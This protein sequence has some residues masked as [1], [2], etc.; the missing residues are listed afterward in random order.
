MKISTKIAAMI[1]ISLAI[2]FA[3]LVFE[4][5]LIS[6]K[7]IAY[8]KQELIVSLKE[9]KK[10]ALQEEVDIISSFIE[11]V[12][13]QYQATNISNEETTTDIL[14][15]TE[16]IKFGLGGYVIIIDDKG[17]IIYHPN[18]EMFKQN[19]TDINGFK[20]V[21]KLIETSVKDEYVE[22]ALLDTNTKSPVR[23]IAN[24]KKINVGGKDMIFI[25]TA[26]MEDAY[27]RA[28]EL[29]KNMEKAA[30]D[31]TKT[32]I[33]MAL[34]IAV[35][36]LILT[37]LYSRASITKP[38]NTLIDRARNLSSGDGDLTRKLEINGKDEIAQ[39]SE[40][41][42]NFI[43]K[44]RILISDAKHLS[45]E[46]SSIANELS[47][48]SL[49]TGKRVE[50]S[51]LIVNNTTQKGEEIQSFMKNS[52][53]FAEESKTELQNASTHI[54]SANKA[55]KELADQITNSAQVESEM[56]VK[57]EQLSRDAEQVK[58]VLDVINDI[59]DQTNLLALNAAIEAARAGEHGRG[60]AVVADEVRK[61][62]ERTQSSLVE[63][64]ATISVIVQAI[65]DSSER[66]SANS[67]TIQELT[68]VAN[69]VENTINVMS[70]AMN[71]AI[72]MS[73]KTTE[74]FI[75][76]GKGVNLMMEGISNI[77]HI[78]TENARSVEEIAA[79][80]EHLNKM[81][82]TLNNKLAEFRT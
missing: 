23:K 59:A 61:L 4:N 69:R 75:N 6:D 52:V 60:F 81:T 15:Y 3:A 64:N 18:A 80:A 19:L 65:G 43:E 82:D 70:E 58:S 42:N 41:I 35:A 44:V 13:R 33:M 50:D 47:S 28:D 56:A 63:I 31:G 22:Y 78:A 38:L 74:D 2:L 76:T 10:V 40:A 9:D 24:S 45:S 37:M 25:I 79:A 30:N 34:G 46:N 62:A 17:Q 57:I 72:G 21:D 36:V 7:S 67:K 49:Q 68:N 53:S 77:N 29:G 8:T 66:M 39:A 26:S 20:Y 48:T 11:T 5:K 16:A 51:T 73:D 27:A 14:A 54:K 71:K 55:I 1:V 12:K 32:F